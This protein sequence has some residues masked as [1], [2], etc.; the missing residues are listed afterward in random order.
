MANAQTIHAWLCNAQYLGEGAARGFT[1][2]M[3]WLGEKEILSDALEMTVSNPQNGT[4][5]A[6]VI[7]TQATRLYGVL[8]V[9]AG[10]TGFLSLYN[11]ASGTVGV[12]ARVDVVAF[13][14]NQ[15]RFVPMYDSNY[16][17]LYG[18][19]LCAGLSTAVASSTA[20]GTAPTA[21]YFLTDAVP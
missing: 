1:D 20:L 21:I 15:T 2:Y 4:G 19:G 17:L 13:G 12:T 5:A 11:A 9:S 14:T 18:T 16:D 3:R 10:S 6:T 8:I 7:S